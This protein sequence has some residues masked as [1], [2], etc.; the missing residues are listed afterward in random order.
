M[1]PTRPQHPPP[2]TLRERQRALARDAIVKA[3]VEHVGEHGSFEVSVG[4]IARRAG[5]SLRTVYNH[6]PSRSELVDAVS[7]WCDEQIRARGGMSEPGDL[8]GLPA[9]IARNFARFEE[10]AGIAGALARVEALGQQPASRIGRTAAF[11]AALAARHPEAE[12]RRI[13]AAAAAIRQLASVRGWHRLTREHGLSL[14]EAT[15]TAT[16]A[17]GLA[18][19]ALERGDWPE[20]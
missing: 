8:D 3:L 2:P 1:A 7:D 20:V 12:P 18:V 6:F 17:T 14:A 16:W 13:T 10:L 11:E 9:A 5:V 4:E 15:A 19:A